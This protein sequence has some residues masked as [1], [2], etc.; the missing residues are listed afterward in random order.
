MRGNE[1]F[2]VAVRSME[3]AS[4]LDEVKMTP[5]DI[6][7]PDASG[8]QRITDAVADRLGVRPEK[9]TQHRKDRQHLV[10]ID[11]DHLDELV[12]SGAYRK[13]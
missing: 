7:L 12:V 8:K 10:G 9:V 11:S 5:N 4:V 2:K 1:L 3:D 6:D 13:A